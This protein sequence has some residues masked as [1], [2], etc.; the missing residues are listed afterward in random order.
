MELSYGILV[1]CCL[2]FYVKITNE[3]KQEIIWKYIES[4]FQ[5]AIGSILLKTEWI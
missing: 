1:V 5:P 4:F 3:I 2:Y